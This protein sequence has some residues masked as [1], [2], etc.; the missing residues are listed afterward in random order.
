MT[1]RSETACYAEAARVE[2]EAFAA[3]TLVRPAATLMPELIDAFVEYATYGKAPSGAPLSYPRVLRPARVFFA[4][5]KVRAVR[6]QDVERFRDWMASG[7]ARVRGDAP[8]SPRTVNETLQL[9]RAAFTMAVRDDLVARNPCTWVK[10]VPVP[11]A[12]RDTWSED[13]VRQFLAVAREDRL[14]ACWLISM[15]GPRRSEVCGLRWEDVK[16]GTLSIRQARVQA[17]EGLSPRARK[18]RAG[19]GELPLFEPV[20]GALASL[21]RA[22]GRGEAGR[23]EAV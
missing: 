5:T 9:L 6:R 11:P 14:H 15:C 19:S 10:N 7:E 16:D 8:L 18:V 13:Q 21:R 4:K 20:T 22:A 17:R 3:G 2:A 12:H 1:A 23:R